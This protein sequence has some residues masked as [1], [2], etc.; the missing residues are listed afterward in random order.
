MRVRLNKYFLDKKKKV[1]ENKDFFSILFNG[2][3]TNKLKSLKNY[4]GDMLA[5]ELSGDFALDASFY[6][7][8]QRF[9]LKLTK[10][11]VLQI[12]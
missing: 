11:A 2:R 5:Q 1:K 12:V 3:T 8:S 9:C 4:L 7:K 10:V 6:Y